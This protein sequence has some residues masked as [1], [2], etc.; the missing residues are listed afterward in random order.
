MCNVAS[1]PR[2]ECSTLVC[3]P[4]EQ[5]R[6]LQLGRANMPAKLQFIGGSASSNADRF[7]DGTYSE[8]TIVVLCG[9]RDAVLK[10]LSDGALKT[11]YNVWA[12]GVMR[13]PG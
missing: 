2:Q 12:I 5:R 1:F 8:A 6:V 4:P 13:K 9:T 10:R 11:T 7:G 3:F